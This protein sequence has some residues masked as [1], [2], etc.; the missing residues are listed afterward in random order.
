MAL[1]F[2]EYVAYPAGRVTV[3]E[4]V[5]RVFHLVVQRFVVEQSRRRVV[6][7]FSAGSCE[8][9]CAGFDGFGALGRVAH[10][11]DGAAERR[12]FLLYSAAVRQRQIRAREER[13][14]FGSVHRLAEDDVFNA[15]EIFFCEL[16]HGGVFVNGVDRQRV[17][18]RACDVGDGGEHIFHVFAYV[19]AAVRRYRDYAFSARRVEDFPPDLAVFR[20]FQRVDRRIADDEYLVVA[21]ALAGEIL[22]RALGRRKAVFC[23]LVYRRAVEFLG[24]GRT[25]V[26]R[27]KPRFDVRDGFFMIAVP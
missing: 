4:R 6:Y 24:V 15:V 21:L 13:V 8:D 26:V 1:Y 18:V 25:Y 9:R 10:D 20:V 23:D 27:A 14:K 12:R 3:A 19:F 5:F 22:R 2:F 7:F 16:L 17:R 11:D